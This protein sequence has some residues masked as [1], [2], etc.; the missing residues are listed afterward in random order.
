MASYDPSGITKRYF[1][2]V[3]SGQYADAS[4]A[5]TNTQQPVVRKAV[6]HEAVDRYLATMLASDSVEYRGSRSDLRSLDVPGRFSSPSMIERL[7]DSLAQ[8][9][10]P[11]NALYAVPERSDA[12]FPRPPGYDLHQTPVRQEYGK[13]SLGQLY[14]RD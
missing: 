10:E 6:S 7:V 8:A 12:Q 2:H 11:M 14:G 3:I 5:R 1:P 13:P 9:R 4:A